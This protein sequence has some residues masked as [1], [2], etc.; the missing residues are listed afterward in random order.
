LTKL[1]NRSR[2]SP[3]DEV[4]DVY[5]FDQEQWHPTSL[6]LPEASELMVAMVPHVVTG[7]AEDVEG[8][9]RTQ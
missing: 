3:G 6:P 9:R 1:L 4:T 5:A 2:S 8:G 7:I